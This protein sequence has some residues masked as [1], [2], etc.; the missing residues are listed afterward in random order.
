[1][2]QLEMFYAE[3]IMMSH[4]EHYNVVELLG[5]VTAGDPKYIVMEFCDHGSLDVYLHDLSGKMA[6]VAE[7]FQT[8]LVVGIAVGMKYL[9][10]LSVVHRDL[11]ARNILLDQTLTA[12]V[13]DFGLSR[14]IGGDGYIIAQARSAGKCSNRQIHF[15]ADGSTHFLHL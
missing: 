2:E 5:V 13:C 7:S 9:E 6:D 3:A 12:K 4:F 11:A 1:M 15:D 10:S 14:C 8:T